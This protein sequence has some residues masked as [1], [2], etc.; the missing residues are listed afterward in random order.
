MPVN[1]KDMYSIVA[2]VAGTQAEFEP[3]IQ[4]GATPPASDLEL[5]LFSTCIRPG[6]G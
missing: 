2:S 4:V 6:I 3:T 5:H 1:A